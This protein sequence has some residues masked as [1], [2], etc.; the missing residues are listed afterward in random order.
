MFATM[1]K[2]E[3]LNMSEMM[4]NLMGLMD[5]NLNCWLVGK[6]FQR[7]PESVCWIW[8]KWPSS[9][10]SRPPGWDVG[11]QAVNQLCLTWLLHHLWWPFTKNFRISST[12][13]CPFL[14]VF[15]S[16]VIKKS[17]WLVETFLFRTMYLFNATRKGLFLYICWNILS[18]T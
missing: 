16:L 8:W 11:L 17:F 14:F 15:F 13:T 9:C 5:Q 7:H 6:E 18:C 1:T 4:M 2:A 3:M 10:S 12:I